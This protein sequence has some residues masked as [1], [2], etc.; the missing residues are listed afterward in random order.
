MPGFAL[1]QKVVVKDLDGNFK[2]QI[3]NAQ[4]Y[5]LFLLTQNILEMLKTKP[6]DYILLLCLKIHSQIARLLT[7]GTTIGKCI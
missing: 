5:I 1:M 3:M 6:Q 4:I 7:S 2:K